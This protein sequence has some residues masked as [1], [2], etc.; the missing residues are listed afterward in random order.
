[1]AE[2]KNSE[3]TAININYLN[4]QEITFMPHKNSSRNCI[5]DKIDEITNEATNQN[6]SQ[7]GKVVNEINGRNTTKPNFEKKTFS[8]SSMKISNH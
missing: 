2:M 1:M 7:A 3:P 8:E 4:V 6:L 5:Q